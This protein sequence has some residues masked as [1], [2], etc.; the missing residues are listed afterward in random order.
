M[1]TTGNT[2]LITG[3]GTGIGLALARVLLKEGNQV[4]ICGR[5]KEVL[6][7]ARRQ[8]P[9]LHTLQCDVADAAGRKSLQ[10]WATRGFPD[11]NILVNNAGI[12]RQIDFRKGVADLW[13]GEDEIT[14]NLLGP[15]HLTALF[16]PHL[17]EQESAAIV[18]ISSGLGFIP[19]AIM[20]VYC[21][22]KAAIH[23]LSLSLRHQLRETSVRVFE[24]IPPTVDTNLDRGARQGRGQAE[25][26]IQPEEVATATL[27]GLAEDEYELAIGQAQLL[28]KGSREDLDQIFQRMNSH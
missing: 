8:L 2:I 10:D 3:G 12:Q 19:L 17:M 18:N 24:V 21:A 13:A 22:T 27:K 5:R 23:S 28:R 16:I 15:V 9:N 6:D 11:L 20:P 4:L 26:G 25:R 14:I 1:K 7:E